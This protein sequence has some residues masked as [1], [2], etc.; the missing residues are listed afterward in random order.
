MRKPDLHTG[1]L[2]EVP[3]PVA[4]YPGVL[5]CRAQIAGVMSEAL[6]GLDRYAVASKMSKLLGRNISKHMLDAWTAESREEHMPAFD[7]AMAF[8]M[9]TEGMAL[10]NFYAHKLGASL[11]VGKE[12]LNWQLGRLEKEKEDKAREI[13]RLRKALGAGK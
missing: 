2:F 13:K 10:L 8:D 4:D 3:Q 6:K 11:V 7:I 5:S 1:D 9:A 12:Y